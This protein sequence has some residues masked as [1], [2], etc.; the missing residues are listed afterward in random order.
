VRG[1]RIGVSAYRRSTR[2]PIVLV[3]LIGLLTGA[4]QNRAVGGRGPG[5]SA[6]LRAW[7]RL[8]AL[9]NLR[10]KVLT[11][12]RYLSKDSHR[13]SVQGRSST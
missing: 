1:K 13:Q 7:D 12:S 11:L 9:P 8:S 3:M 5:L 10:G 6:L 2:S 4:G